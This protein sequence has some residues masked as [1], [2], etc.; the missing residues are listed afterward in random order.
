VSCEWTAVVSGIQAKE[1]DHFS[2]IIYCCCNLFILALSAGGRIL[3]F[4]SSL[5]FLFLFYKEKRKTNMIK[6]KSIAK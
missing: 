4:S 2:S 6:E 3:T 5:D 1:T